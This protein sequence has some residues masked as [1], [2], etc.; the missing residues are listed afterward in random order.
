[1]K[2]ILNQDVKGQGKKGQLVEV[3]DGYA[4]NFLLPRKLAK[5]ATSENINVMKGQAEAEEYRKMTELEQAKKDAA[6][7][8]E[9]IVEL[10]AKAGENGKL[11][12]SITGKDVA[13]ALKMQHHIKLDK[14]KFAM[15]DGIKVLGTTIVDVKVY[16]GV[17]A[18]LKVKVTEQK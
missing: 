16:P 10:T 9:V 13:E 18:K 15:S 1:M 3:S 8:E 12:G 17:T 11:F 2:V 4:R 6:K 14:K 7:I 5:E